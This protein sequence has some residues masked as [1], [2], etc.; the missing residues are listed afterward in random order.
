MER[1]ETALLLRAARWPGPESGP[2]AFAL[3]PP[4]KALRIAALAEDLEAGRFTEE[5]LPTLKL[6][7]FPWLPELFPR[8][9]EALFS[10]LVALKEEEAYFVPDL[11]GWFSLLKAARESWGR[12][13]GEQQHFNPWAGDGGLEVALALRTPEGVRLLA[14]W[15][16]EGF[17]VGVEGE[18]LEGAARLARGGLPVPEEAAA[19]AAAQIVLAQLGL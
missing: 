17:S 1:S 4:E 9:E 6:Y 19:Q 8:A 12:L 14:G 2:R 7:L 13:S 16:G 3:V 15:G 5:N 18:V 10:G 11:L